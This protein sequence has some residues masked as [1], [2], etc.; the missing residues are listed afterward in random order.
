MRFFQRTHFAFDYKNHQQMLKHYDCI[1]HIPRL[2][3]AVATKS[4]TDKWNSII[5]SFDT[6]SSEERM[7]YTVKDNILTTGTTTCASEILSE[8]DA[9]FDASV[10]GLLNAKG[11][12]M[13]GKT[14]LD[15]FGMGSSNTNSIF[16][17]SI[18]PQFND[19]EYVTGG[20]SGGAAASVAAGLCEF[21]IGT[22][23]GG[24]VRLPASNCGIYGFKPSYGRLSRW[25][26][27]PY[28]QTLDTVGIMSRKIDVLQEVFL[29]L[30]QHDSK[31]PTS[32][33]PTTRSQ[34]QE[35]VKQRDTER[36]G[37]YTIG[38][39]SEFLVQELTDDS[40]TKLAFV[41]EKLSSMGHKIVPVSIPSIE[42]LLLAYYT[43]AT[44]EAAS[45]LS[46]YDGVR[47]GKYNDSFFGADEIIKGNR[48]TGF[49]EEVQRRIILGNY[50]MSS[51]SGDHY[52]KATELRKLL[53]DE[54]NQIF[55]LPNLLTSSELS[56]NDS[57]TCDYLIAPTSMSKPVKIKEFLEEEKKNILESYTNDILTTPMSLAGIPTISIPI[58]DKDDIKST[59]GVQ[60][61]G[62]YGDD[63]GVL[64]LTRELLEILL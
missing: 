37:T 44:A 28:A 57:S 63:S 19:D 40:R 60:M 61:I 33:P 36:N 52:A 34:I 21:S 59:Q 47:Y 48:T 38:I 4:G 39:P 16:G 55:Y 17:P 49:G 12:L 6:A 1:S 13:T 56:L 27:I 11:Y 50:T 22:D 32:L 18:N 29:V 8:F 51:D 15:Q 23:T 20:S 26:V 35:L 43:I 2:A 14:N 64:N 31:D 3:R 46:R 7:K 54:F 30:D 10:V 24:S 62:Q 5:N 9:P 53:V 45:N 58:N 25:G 41:A 42:N